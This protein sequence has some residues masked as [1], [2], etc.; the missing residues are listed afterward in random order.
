MLKGAGNSV[1]VISA[2]PEFPFCD[3]H[4]CPGGGH[5]CTGQIAGAA[6]AQWAMWLQ[7]HVGCEWDRSMGWWGLS[8]K[9][10][11]ANPCADRS[12][13]GSSLLKSFWVPER[14]P[15]QFARCSRSFPRDSWKHRGRGFA[16]KALALLLVFVVPCSLALAVM[17]VL[18]PKVK[19]REQ[20]QCRSVCRGFSFAF[21]LQSM[22][23]GCAQRCPRVR[24]NHQLCCRSVLRVS[25]STS[26]LP[27]SAPLLS[28]ILH[29]NDSWKGSH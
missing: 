14:K 24:L 26:L 20:D 13:P 1:S 12:S 28:C 10:H 18:A 23:R 19:R 7:Y 17:S 25:K 9:L 11:K 3:I 29:L 16:R 6:A 21:P 27:G 4:I 8:S 22:S 5:Y 2:A 15:L